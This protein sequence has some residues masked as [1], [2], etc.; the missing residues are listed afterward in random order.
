MRMD[1]VTIVETFEEWAVELIDGVL[2]ECYDEND[3]R[4]MQVMFG[5]EVKSHTVF[6]GEWTNAV[7]DQSVAEDTG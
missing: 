2:L 3:A 4:S 6:V 5:G 7:A 1:N